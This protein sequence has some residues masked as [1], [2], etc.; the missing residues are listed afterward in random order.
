MLF[1]PLFSDLLLVD[2]DL[3]CALFVALVSFLRLEQTVLQMSHL[4][5]ALIVQ[6]VDATMEDNLEA[7]H[8]GEGTLFLVSELVPCLIRTSMA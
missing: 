8:F 4:D 7:V 3:V 5:I 6:L 2:H 1:L